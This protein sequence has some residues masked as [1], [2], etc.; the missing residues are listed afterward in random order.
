[1]HWLLL[2]GGGPRAAFGKRT[3]V[4]DR[5]LCVH[6]DEIA[7]IY[8]CVMKRVVL[9]VNQLHLFGWLSSNSINS[10]LLYK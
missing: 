1:M 2:V 3:K 9:M 10:E 6:D 4:S 5:H 8:F 7:S